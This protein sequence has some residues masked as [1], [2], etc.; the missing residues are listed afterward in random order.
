MVNAVKIENDLD[1]FLTEHP[2]IKIIFSTDGKIQRIQVPE[3]AVI[4]SLIIADSTLYDL[5]YIHN[6]K[7]HQFSKKETR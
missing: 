2:E 1:S 6:D 4:V 5:Q 7:L 3:D